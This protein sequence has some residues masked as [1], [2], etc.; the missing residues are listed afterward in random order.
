M[1]IEKTDK[2]FEDLFKFKD[3]IEILD[4]VYNK[5]NE[6]SKSFSMKE[7][8]NEKIEVS[9]YEVYKRLSTFYFYRDGYI[10]TKN[11][12]ARRTLKTAKSTKTSCYCS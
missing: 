9:L 8:N 7:E 3:S 10:A 2:Y 4:D 5:L 6:L 11:C 1:S 12:K